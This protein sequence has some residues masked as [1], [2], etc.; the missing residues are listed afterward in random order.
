[1]MRI[2]RGAILAAVLGVPLVVGCATKVKLDPATVNVA[3]GLSTPYRVHPGD[4]LEIKFKY[5]PA[6]NTT[7]TVDTDGRLNMPMTGELQV[8]GLLL[9]ELEKLIVERASRFMRDPVVNI[10]VA[11]SESKA[12]IGGEVIDEGFVTLTRPMTVLQAVFERGGFGPGADLSDVVILSHQEGQAVARQIDL[13]AELE[14]DPSERTLLAADEIVF[15]PK[16]AVAKANQFVDEYI[17]KMMP[18]FLTRMIR[19]NP[20]GP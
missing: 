11:T 8:S 14:G 17:N 19:F 15:V 10:T 13:E 12:Y 7:A 20:I 1:M 9:P 4:I 2:Y 16:T 3:Q 18:D 5:H 6:D